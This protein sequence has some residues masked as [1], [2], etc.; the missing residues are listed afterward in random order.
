MTYGSWAYGAGGAAAASVKSNLQA[1]LFQDA[2]SF[3]GLADTAHDYLL[4][5]FPT[6]ATSGM[7]FGAAN[8]GASDATTTSDDRFPLGYVRQHT[9]PTLANSRASCNIPIKPFGHTKHTK[10]WFFATALAHVGDVTTNFRGTAGLLTASGLGVGIGILTNLSTTHYVVQANAF[11]D[12]PTPSTDR[13]LI[14]P[15]SIGASATPT[16]HMLYMWYVPGSPH[17]TVYA[18]VDRGTV[19]STVSV[20][21]RAN[22]FYADPLP[23]FWCENAGPAAV[24]EQRWAWQYIAV[25]VA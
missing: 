21:L 22:G 6:T 7:T 4:R 2:I 25:D 17:S 23:Y 11:H 24:K 9:S 15:I 16:V 18:C 3:G 13:A 1:R 19:G 8:G 12:A 20:E 14:A 10:R 5:P